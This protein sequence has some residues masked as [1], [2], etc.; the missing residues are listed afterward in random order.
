[1]KP[2]IMVRY[3]EIGLKGRNRAFFLRLLRQ[4]LQQALAPLGTADVW[5]AQGRVF[6][7]WPCDQEE[8]LERLS[9]VF[10]AVALCPTWQVE[11]RWEAIKVAAEREVEAAL[12]RGRGLS[13]KVEARRSNKAFPLD[14][15]EINRELGGH[16]LQCFPELQ[17]DVHQPMLRVRVE[18]RDQAY[19]YA[20]E[21]PGPGGLPVGSSGRAIAL[22]SGGI[23]SPVACWFA[24]KRGLDCY[25]VYFHSPPFTG[26]RVKEKVRDLCRALLPYGMARQLQVVHFTEVQKTLQQETPERLGT[27]L[28]RRMMMRLADRIAEDNGALALVTGESLGQ[29]ASQTLEALNCTDAVVNR[30]VIRPLVGWDKQEIIARAQELGT[31][32][33]SIQPYADCCT[34]FVPR[35]PQTRPCRQRV[36]EAER[37]LDIEKLMEEALARSEVLSID[38]PVG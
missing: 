9:R 8:A 19:V 18:I 30:L 10:G 11:P 5:D 35:H 29:V 12:S 33:I 21:V 15:M 20:R 7:R 17:V 28:M 36:E 22:L 13:F 34:L 14:S 3:G 32:P 24:M 16:L 2:L 27:V 26:E 37:V 38:L 1:M 4:N 25:P 6:L 31:Y 23:D